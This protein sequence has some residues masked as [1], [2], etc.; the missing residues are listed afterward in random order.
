M[1][2]TRL[3][4]GTV[5]P[6]CNATMLNAYLF[7]SESVTVQCF[8]THPPQ[9]PKSLRN[10]N[11][12]KHQA[13]PCEQAASARQGSTQVGGEHNHVVNC[14][15]SAPNLGRVATNE[16]AVVGWCYTCKAAL[17]TTPIADHKSYMNGPLALKHGK[18]AQKTSQKRL[19]MNMKPGRQRAL[20]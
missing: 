16:M 3:T 9:N 2:R 4:G 8:H 19:A 18:S 17:L 5:S 20:L 13:E 14:Q 6:A 7:M 11:H 10:P 15:Y 12:P 1:R